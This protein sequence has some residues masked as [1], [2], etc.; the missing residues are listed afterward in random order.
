MRVLLGRVRWIVGIGGFALAVGSSASESIA[1]SQGGIESDT[2]EIVM[3]RSC[4]GCHDLT[5]IRTQALDVDGWREVVQS[6][7]TEYGA[8]VAPDDVAPLTEY[9]ATIYDPLPEGAGREILLERCTIC[10]NRDRIW[11]HAGED[12]EHWETTLLSMLN[13]GASLSDREFETLLNYLAPD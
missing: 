7:M 3:N 12:R 1:L 10:H 6:M 8:M 13:E 5:P 4:L 2:G 11:A 9:L